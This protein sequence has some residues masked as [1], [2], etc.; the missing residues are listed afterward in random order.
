MKINKIITFLLFVLF[1]AP[2]VIA[3]QPEKI[4]FIDLEYDKGTLELIDIS[5]ITGYPQIST[6]DSLPYKLELL[7]IEKEILYQGY[8]DIPNKFSTPPPLSPE[9][10]SGVVELSNVNFS[11]SLP[12][13]KKGNIINII[14]DEKILL[15][16][17]VSKF[18]MYC[19]D[20]ICQSDENNQNCPQDCISPDVSPIQEED[21]DRGN[22]LYLIII[23][24][25]IL[26]GIIII[27]LKK[28]NRLK[29]ESNYEKY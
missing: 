3:L 13:Y 28:R 12:Y 5:I 10:K 20:S 19:G 27:Y 22:R 6:D 24:L 8:F 18:S 16:I 25:I 7:S 21:E 26:L 9:D 23:P 15:R 4:Y 17:D 11:I 29:S 1:I 2:S 14:K